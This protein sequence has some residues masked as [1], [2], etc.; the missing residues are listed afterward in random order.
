MCHTSSPLLR[1]HDGFIDSPSHDSATMKVKVSFADLVD[2]KSRL[3][4]MPR[5]EDLGLGAV[6]AGYKPWTNSPKVCDTKAKM[7][8]YDDC[9]TKV[10]NAKNDP[11][12]AID[13]LASGGVIVEKADEWLMP[14]RD[15]TPVQHQRHY[16]IVESPVVEPGVP[17]D[18]KRDTPD[19][20]KCSDAV[21]DI[22][23]EDIIGKSLVA[24][25]GVEREED[26]L[27]QDFALIL[28]SLHDVKN[29][30]VLHFDSAPLGMQHETEEQDEAM[31]QVTRT[32]QDELQVAVTSWSLWGKSFAATA[33][34]SAKVYASATAVAVA[35]A[36][37]EARSARLAKPSSHNRP[38]D[39][40][41]CLCLHVGDGQFV[42]L[43]GLLQKVPKVT[44]TSELVIRETPSRAC[45]RNGYRYEWYRS[46]NMPRRCDINSKSSRVP[47][48]IDGHQFDSDDQ[49]WA[50]L[51]GAISSSYKPCAND[52]GHRLRCVVSV[53]AS[54]EKSEFAEDDLSRHEVEIVLETPAP[55][56][57]DMAML[58]GARQALLRGAHFG[59]LVGRGLGEGRIFG[60]TVSITLAD[61]KSISSA[62]SIQQFSG[63]TAEP[64]HQS[65]IKQAYAIADPA[66]PK[67]FDLVFLLGIPQ[68]SMLSA[69]ST[70]GRFQLVAPNR[71]TRE[72]LLLALGIANFSGRPVDLTD[73][74]VLYPGL[75]EYP[76]AIVQ[77]TK[78]TPVKQEK[79]R[80]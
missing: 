20:V 6:V 5:I 79:G 68:G 1:L 3:V 10:D 15:A 24:I 62:I 67:Y 66:N 31:K 27:V 59:N 54:D 36:A 2:L 18:T 28:A 16:K 32:H 23:P 47:P 33:A 7:I 42:E 11:S 50:L 35:R 58:N 70:D 43:T 63:T 74:T 8:A 40:K 77:D 69:L 46:L 41:C 29:T 19:K 55:I 22:N 56:A 30:I 4:L 39:Q 65:L 71:T 60:I 61:D 9:E 73:T 48:N 14:S 78:E 64:I 34:S 13:T 72:M 37:E 57:A 38:H 76:A 12:R 26:W 75:V 80:N 17:D 49:R 44:T 51:D 45:P 25:D 52:I 21:N 53:E